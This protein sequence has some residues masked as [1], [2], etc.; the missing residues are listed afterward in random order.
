[1][2]LYGLRGFV[3][4]DFILNYLSNFSPETL[5][6]VDFLSDPL[7]PVVYFW[8]RLVISLFFLVCFLGFITNY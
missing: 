7:L 3:N 8:E 6:C 1:M 2:F 5:F 4:G